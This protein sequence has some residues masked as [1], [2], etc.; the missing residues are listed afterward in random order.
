M[1]L[2]L[3]FTY[4][5]IMYKTFSAEGY[6]E[7]EFRSALKEMI[8]KTDADNMSESEVEQI[9]SLKETLMN[10]AQ[11]LFAKLYEQN[12]PGVN[13]GTGATSPNYSEDGDVVD[14]EYKEV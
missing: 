7:E 6:T 9:K 14:G 8:E 13:A 3:I 5:D 12:G 10:S 11:D 4:F 1:D 2:C